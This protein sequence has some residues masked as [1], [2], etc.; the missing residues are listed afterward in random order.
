MAS[1]KLDTG[2]EVIP[3]DPKCPSG[4]KVRMEVYGFQVINRVLPLVY[5]SVGLVGSHNNHLVIFP[6]L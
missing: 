3:K 2:S 6:V 4:P 1:G 5:L